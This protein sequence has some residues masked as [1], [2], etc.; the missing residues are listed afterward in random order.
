MCQTGIRT[1]RRTIPVLLIFTALWMV[2]GSDARHLQQSQSR[3]QRQSGLTPE[4][5][6]S[7]SNYGPED[8]FPGEA[9][10]RQQQDRSA[11]RQAQ[12]RRPARGS[13]SS[14]AQTPSPT[15][16]PIPVSTPEAAP[17][18]SLPVN[19]DQSG[20][21]SLSSNPSQSPPDWLLPVLAALS[22]LVLTAFLYTL[23]KLYEK[24]REGRR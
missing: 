3:G 14:P 12:N 22:L 19:S 20:A 9:A 1:I 23:H 13:A 10:D 2:R 11:T 21:G 5:K 18:L 16:T 4:K 8:V 24:M 15:A 7:L 17:S 6:R